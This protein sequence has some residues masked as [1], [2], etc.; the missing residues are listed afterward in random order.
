MFLF[1]HLGGVGD[2]FE[3]EVKLGGQNSSLFLTQYV[4]VTFRAHCHIHKVH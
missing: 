1:T 3:M 4:A 2:R